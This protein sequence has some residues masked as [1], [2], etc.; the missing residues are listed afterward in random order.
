LYILYKG[1]DKWGGLLYNRDIDNVKGERIM[2]TQIIS[3][4]MTISD[5][6]NVSAVQLPAPSAIKPIT[7]WE[8]LIGAN[9]PYIG[10]RVDGGEFLAYKADIDG[11]PVSLV[12]FSWSQGGFDGVVLADGHPASLDEAADIWLGCTTLEEHEGHPINDVVKM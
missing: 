7:A 1:V 4:F 10:T 5:G 9:I 8:T 2:N 6:V 11:K 12:F 3:D